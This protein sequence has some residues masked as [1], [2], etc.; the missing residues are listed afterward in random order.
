MEQM[1]YYLSEFYVYCVYM[2]HHKYSFLN[3]SILFYRIQTVSF[4]SLSSVVL[5][6]ESSYLFILG[7]RPLSS[8]THQI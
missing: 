4:C 3:Y 5:S 8:C 6:V 2:F 1:F 7:I